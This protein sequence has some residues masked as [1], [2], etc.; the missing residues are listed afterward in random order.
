M[1]HSPISLATAGLADAQVPR[2][3]L[4]FLRITRKPIPRKAMRKTMND[5]KSV[6]IRVPDILYFN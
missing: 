4:S 5:I 1:L 6:A 2:N 3:S